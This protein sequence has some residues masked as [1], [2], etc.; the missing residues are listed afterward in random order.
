MKYKITVIAYDKNN[1]YEAEMAQY[2]ERR[3]NYS[4]MTRYPDEIEKSEP[5]LEKETRALM[6]YLNEEEYQQIKKGVLTVFK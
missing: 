6:V 3:D 5:S 2:K 1:D 4:R